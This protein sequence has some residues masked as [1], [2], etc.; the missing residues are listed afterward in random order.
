M[1]SRISETDTIKVLYELWQDNHMSIF[2]IKH[3]L[4]VKHNLNLISLTNCEVI[5]E[6]LD[7]KVKY[8]IK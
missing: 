5:V 3:I 1:I 8:L 6:S 4:L 2:D 7:K